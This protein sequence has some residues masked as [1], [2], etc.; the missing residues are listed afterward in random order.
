MVDSASGSQIHSNNGKYDFS[1]ESNRQV[2]E[3]FLCNLQSAGNL[4]EAEIKFLSQSREKVFSK[5]V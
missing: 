2:V 4:S 1:I 5:I 3:K